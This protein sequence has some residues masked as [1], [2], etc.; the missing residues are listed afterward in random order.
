[1]NN[2]VTLA[3][4][5]FPVRAEAQKLF[6][7]S[8]GITVYLTDANTVGM[9]WLLS[10]AVGGMKLQV[11]AE[12]AQR[13]TQLLED[14]HMPQTPGRE[15]PSNEEITFPCDKCGKNITFSTNRCGHVET[16]PHCGDYVDVPDD[17]EG[18]TLAESENTPSA[19][20]SRRVKITSAAG[21]ADD[22]RKKWQLWLEVSAVLCLA[23]VPFMYGSI[24]SFFLGRQESG[25]LFSYEMSRLVEALQ[26]SMPVLAIMAL[27]RDAWSKF[28]IV[29][30][31]WLTDTLA[32]I[33]IFTIN[34]IARDFVFSLLPQSFWRSTVI[35]IHRQAPAGLL[36]HLLLAFT[37]LLA[38]FSE[39]LVMRGYLIPRLEQLLKST[40]KAVL[41]TSLLFASYHLYQGFGS[42]IIVAG[43]GLVY[44][45][46]FCLFR[47][48]WPLCIA[49]AIHNY[50]VFTQVYF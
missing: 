26:M 38:A 5:D 8:H 10:N 12:D 14:F 42:T 7:E 27:S 25:S 30:P 11:A 24:V 33:G 31:S 43:Y 22:P 45:T 29:R 1:M 40:W 32:A 2:L 9:D 35:I 19:A 6:L 49:H 21:L 16:C 48:L 47:R 20:A 17:V 50:F 3:S 46:A 36:E 44:G 39:E 18:R 13:A 34:I 15:G 41:V 23:Y 28:G 37:L 4:F